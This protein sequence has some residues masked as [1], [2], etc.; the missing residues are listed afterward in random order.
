MYVLL[1]NTH[2]LLAAATISGFLLRG[3]WMMSESALLSHKVTRIAPH[4]VDTLFLL[5]G[6]AL[7]YLLSLP[8]P[9]SPWIL[10][11]FAGLLVY[12]ALGAIALRRGPTLQVRLIAFVGAVSAFAYVVGAAMAKSP[13]SWLAY[14]NP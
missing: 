12:I 9:Q 3:Y 6:A 1:K 7:V 2:M 14:L 13:A 4:A 10:A 5:S 8:I 11:K